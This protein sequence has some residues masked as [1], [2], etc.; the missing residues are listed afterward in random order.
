MINT[1]YISIYYLN[2][3]TN[4]LLCFKARCSAAYAA[5][6]GKGSMTLLGWLWEQDGSLQYRL[7][8]VELTTLR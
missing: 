6:D 1:G 5:Q 8:K 2:T 4:S 3:A 7:R